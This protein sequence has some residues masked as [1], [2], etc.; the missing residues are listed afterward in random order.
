MV[1]RLETLKRSLSRENVHLPCDEY[2]GAFATAEAATDLASFDCLKGL[3][4]PAA[5]VATDEAGAPEGIPLRMT[6]EEVDG[7]GG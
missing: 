5:A 2:S 7:G 4:D 3:L 1:E 6:V